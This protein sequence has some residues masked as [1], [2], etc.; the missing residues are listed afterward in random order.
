MKKYVVL[1]LLIVSFLF[2]GCAPKGQ[3]DF[4]DP[5]KADFN[6]TE[7]YNPDL[8]AL[9]KPDK[10][11][12]IYLDENFEPLDDPSEA[13][14][15]ALTNV[16][17][18]KILELSKLYDTQVKI[19][20]DQKDLVNIHIDQ[21]NALKEL[22]EIKEMQTEQYRSMFTTAQNQFIQERYDNK[23]SSVLRESSLYAI[24]IGTIL[25]AIIAL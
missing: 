15:A 25:L 4:Y 22:V 21:I 19:I 6:K 16:D 20:D 7:Q 18:K 13:K 2:V 1:L 8:S 17:L 12:F 11:D 9:E 10:P 14:Y 3:Y 23:L 24:T 5:P